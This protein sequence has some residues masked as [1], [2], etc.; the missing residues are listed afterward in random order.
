MNETKDDDSLI[1]CTSRC[2]PTIESLIWGED[3]PLF[4]LPP[5]QP[6][7]RSMWRRARQVFLCRSTIGNSMRRPSTKELG[8][9]RSKRAHHPAPE[10]FDYTSSSSQEHYYSCDCTSFMTI[11]T[12]RDY[13]DM[14][15]RSPMPGWEECLTKRARI[16]A[17]PFHSP[18]ALRL[19]DVR[20]VLFPKEESPPPAAPREDFY[21]VDL[22]EFGDISS[23]ALRRDALSQLPVEASKQ[24]NSDIS[25]EA[26]D[27]C[28]TT[29]KNSFSPVTWY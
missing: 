21:E 8:P 26:Q 3:P 10:N 4:A 16:G 7:V 22:E 17:G 18:A 24:G 1:S 29:N 20:R 25:T 15:I 13:Q 23:V 6:L 27:G 19:S 2:S 28:S 12:K 9:P 11:T 5:P 14:F